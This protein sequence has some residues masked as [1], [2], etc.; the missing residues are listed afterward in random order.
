MDECPIGTYKF[1]LDKNICI[2]GITVHSK[3]KNEKCSTC[4]IESEERDLCVT[5]N[6]NKKYY[7]KLNDP[8]NYDTY[9]DCHKDLDKYY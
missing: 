1:K 7:Q 2:L 3:C 4:C 6:E 5:C 8:K 9:I